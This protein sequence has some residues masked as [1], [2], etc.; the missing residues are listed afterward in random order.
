VR[1]R[2]A[3]KTIQQPEFAFAPKSNHGRGSSNRSRDWGWRW[4][5]RW[6]RI[7]ERNHGNHERPNRLDPRPNHN[8]WF[9]PDSGYLTARNGGTHSRNCGPDAGYCRFGTGPQHDPGDDPNGTNARDNADS[10]HAR[11]QPYDSCAEQR[12]GIDQSV[13]HSGND[14]SEWR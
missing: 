7:S 12:S 4:R 8:S 10:V 13:H 11:D 1:E 2:F 5:W 9:H 6:N 3:R 14:I